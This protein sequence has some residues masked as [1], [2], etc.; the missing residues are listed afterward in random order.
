MKDSHWYLVQVSDTTMMTKAA[1]LLGQLKMNS[2]LIT[3]NYTAVK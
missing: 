2:R 1:S 3:K